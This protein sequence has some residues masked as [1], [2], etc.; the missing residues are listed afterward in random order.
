MATQRTKFALGLF[1][2]FGVGMAV[3][4]VI[5]LGMSRYLEKGQFYATYF[6]ESVQGLS[7]DSPVKYRGVSV[8]RVDRITVAPD[9][10]LIQV[11]LK[12]ES[13][14]TLARD[15]VAQLKAVGI[16]GSMFVELDRRGG[17]ESDK[18]PRLSFPS[19][20]PI[21]AS[22]PSNISE[23]WQGIDDVIKKI[24]LLDLEGIS[25]RIKW[26]LENMNGMIKGA[27]IN[28]ISERMKRSLDSTAR[29]LDDSRWNNILTSVEEAGQALKQ[30]TAKADV[31]FSRI[32]ST[33]NQVEGIATDN[34]GNIHAAVLNFRKAAEQAH[35]LLEDGTS[36]VN[37]VDDSFSQIGQELFVL[38]QNLSEATEN[39]NRFMGLVSDH[40]SQLIWGEP[41]IPKKVENGT[42]NE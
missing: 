18:S 23:L 3:V 1:V 2:T 15:M 8:G 12:I 22:K 6:N 4:A 13:G 16:T 21:V 36:M 28:G 34:A 9:A 41:P 20:Y 25:V 7:I 40:P 14:Q 17:D 10:N 32:E 11:V 31:G 19:E 33:L 30:L 27:D 29:L 42:A 39:L 24:R 35:N 26:T 38:I 37:D 5:W